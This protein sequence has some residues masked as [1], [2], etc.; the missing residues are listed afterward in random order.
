MHLT[1]KHEDCSSLSN[2]FSNHLYSFTHAVNHNYFSGQKDNFMVF[3]L[4]DSF[5]TVEKQNKQMAKF[6]TDGRL[7]HYDSKNCKR[8]IVQKEVYYS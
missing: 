8:K 7:R 2:Y 1:Y 3:L 6:N 4:I 5:M